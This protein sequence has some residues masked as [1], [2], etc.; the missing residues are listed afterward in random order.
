[1]TNGKSMKRIHSH[2]PHNAETMQTVCEVCGIEMDLRPKS[3]PTSKRIH[4]VT[5]KRMVDDSPD[6][7]WLGEYSDKAT[8]EYSIDREHT[9]AEQVAWYNRCGDRPWLAERIATMTTADMLEDGVEYPVH[10]INK[11]VPRGADIEY[12]CGIVQPND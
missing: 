4:K 5:I 11:H 12:L 3:K 6:T 8:S 7:S 9:L 2:V 1:M 10:V